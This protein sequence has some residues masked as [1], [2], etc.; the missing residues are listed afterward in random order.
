MHLWNAFRQYHR[1]LYFELILLTILRL[2]GEGGDGGRSKM[3]QWIVTQFGALM[4]RF[5]S[6]QEHIRQKPG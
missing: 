5:Y 1:Y 4:L 2:C 6:L 3:A